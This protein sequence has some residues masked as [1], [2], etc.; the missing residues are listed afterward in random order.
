VRFEVEL[1]ERLGAAIDV[2]KGL[3][4][5]VLLLV[6]LLVIVLEKA[7]SITSTSTIRHGGLS[8]STL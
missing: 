3:F 8:T 7:H 2:F 1:F 4:V 5:L 6:L